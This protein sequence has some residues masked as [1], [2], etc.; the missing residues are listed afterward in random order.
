MLLAIVF[1]YVFTDLVIS[2]DDLKQFCLID[3]DKFL[4]LNGKELSEYDCMP[5]ILNPS[6]VIFNN[7]L[8]ANEL[9]YDHEEM[10]AKHEEHFKLLNSDQ[11]SAYEKIV[12]VVD[13]ELDHMFFVDGYGGIGKTFLWN[14]L[15]YHF[16]S[17]GKIVLNVASSSIASLLLPRGRTAHSQFSIPLML[18]EES[19]C[20]IEKE[21]NK[22][23]LLTMASLII[24]DE[25]PMISRLAFEAF[26]RTMR[27]IMSNVVDGASNLPFGGKTVV[28]G[29][30]F[31]Q[32]LPVVPKRGRA[33]IVDA[34]I[35]SSMLWRR[36][37]VLKLT[38]N[39]R[40][41]FP[42]NG[43]DDA[44]LRLFARW[45]LDVG[46]GKLGIDNDG[47]AVI[48]IPDDICLKNSGNHVGDIVESTY[49]NLLSNMKE[50]SFFQDR[51]ILAPTLELVEKVNDYVL[52]LVP[53]EEKEYLS[54]DT[55]LKCDEEVG[56][57]R[58]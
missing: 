21:G 12:N 25:A 43:Q 33:D 45:I 20:T 51:A 9:W 27:D 23:Q 35:N 47:E 53:G 26:D 57:D 2:E 55:V 22:A 6:P 38:K 17:E 44:S 10:F 15:S 18:L 36:C 40:L 8:L 54:C 46:D 14:A 48:E 16:R 5:K 4:R 28:L 39:I 7:V 29:G 13:N 42:T 56:I 58:R 3:I 32:I 50:S 37:R 30:D 34:C 31:R 41:Q 24:W 52:S 19:G 49:P 1:H 11:L